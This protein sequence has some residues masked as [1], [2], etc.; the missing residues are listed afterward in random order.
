MVKY[1]ITLFVMCIFSA[2]LYQQPACNA[3]N[4]RLVPTAKNIQKTPFAKLG[5]EIR[6]AR[7]KNNWSE[8]AFAN[9]INISDDEL[10]RIETGKQTPSKEKLYQIEEVLEKTFE[11]E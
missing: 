6:A 5:K 1:L 10:N 11:M 8:S 4:S 9:I 3:T 2:L 7:L